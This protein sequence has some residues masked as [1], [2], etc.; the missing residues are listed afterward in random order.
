MRGAKPDARP[1]RAALP[2]VPRAPTWMHKHAKAEWRRVAPILVER[3]VLTDGDLG[4]LEGYAVAVGTV[5]ECADE[6]RRDGL[7][8]L[9]AK[10]T[11]KRHPATAIQLAA[12]Q[13]ARLAANELGLTPVSRSRPAIRTDDAIEDDGL[14][15]L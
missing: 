6:L 5:R 13:A 12:L 3:R 7:T 9:D 2:S 10:G 14:G 1:D 8:Y 15:D 11:R 4:T